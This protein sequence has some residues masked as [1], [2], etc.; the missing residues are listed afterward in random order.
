MIRVVLPAHLRTLAG[1]GSEVQLELSG[2]VT[3][4]AV[5]D[6]LEERFPVLRGTIR[7]HVTL[8]RRAYVRFFACAEDFSHEPSDTL[9]PDSVTSGKE[10]FY[11]VG[12]IAGGLDAVS[13]RASFAF[14]PASI[15]RL[16]AR[17]YVV[18]CWTAALAIGVAVLWADQKKALWFDEII[19]VTLA[20]VSFATLW[21][22][23]TTGTDNNPP[24]LY[25]L[26]DPLI[27]IL[28]GPEMAV[29]LVSGAAFL[30][31]AWCLYRL[32][33]PYTTKPFAIAAGF[34]PLITFVAGYIDEARP[35]V[36]ALAFVAL[37]LLL[38]QRAT[39][40]NRRPA[41]IVGLALAVAC[42]LSSHFSATL[43]V[44]ALFAG[45]C[46]RTL[47]RRRIDW[48]VVL[49]IAAGCIP[50]LFFLP[51]VQGVRNV[52]GAGAFWA[53]PTLDAVVQ[54]TRDAVLPL[55][56][57]AAII[58]AAVIL[59]SKSRESVRSPAP[60]HEWIAWIVLLGAPVEG[61]VQSRFTGAFTMRYAMAMVLPFS[62][63]LAL[64]CD[65]ISRGS[66]V[67]AIAIVAICTAAGV[68]N[69]R[70]SV[71]ERPNP[72]R[73]FQQTLA[74]Q[75][76]PDQPL[77][78]GT[79][80]LYLPLQHYAPE[81]LHSRLIYLTAPDLALK[82]RG[83]NT[84]DLNIEHL[85]QFSSLRVVGYPQF[86]AKRT[87]FLVLMRESDHFT[88]LGKQLAAD[89]V[90]LQKLACASVGCLYQAWK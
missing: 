19:T 45:E 53:I 42:A 83:T 3:M 78:I 34:L 14:V 6:A 33:Q 30:L 60:V 4:G 72:Y 5:L 23:L 81:P 37:S 40:Q 54:Q 36:L 85:A 55:K 10:P 11:I 38:W 86:I 46:A 18:F 29:R 26:V 31:T 8:K 88:W 17:Y 7:D 58:L 90:P 61:Y 51:I 44:G 89:S 87:P 82:Q 32:A 74:A 15:E 20:R 52:I 47:L 28:P 48:A 68:Q 66:V 22:A 56:I 65:R 12:A 50:L 75:L 16:A 57:L 39:S 41:H 70:K 1:T 49:G 24:L 35:Y 73:Q 59:R 43:L 63:V 21:T 67:A 25:L 84:P 27:R 2:P 76:P 69:L 13:E 62:L 71:A 77:V 79:P 9:L 80:L 64:V